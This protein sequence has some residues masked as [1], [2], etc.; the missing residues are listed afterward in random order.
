M[1]HLYPARL[2]SI[3]LVLSLLLGMVW[4]APVTE[5]E[6]V[7]GIDS[8]SC[9]GFI[10]NATA[11]NY[12]DV[13]M[14]HYLND[15]SKLRTAL[16]NGKNVIFMFEGGS[17]NYWNGS[18]YTNSA[19]DTRDQAVVNVVRKNSGGNAYIDFYSENCSS[20]PGDPSWCTGAAYSGSVTVLDGIYPV[21]TTNHTGPY[22]AL[23]LDMS[24]TNGY[25]YYTPP[26]SPDGYK[27]GCSGINVHTR[28]SD[29]A[30]GSD[31]GWAWSEGCQ[32]IG[33]G[34]TS[35]NVFN[36]FMHSVCDISWDPWIDYYASPKNLNRFASSDLYRDVGYFVID[37][38]LGLTNV[39]GTQY[40]T[41]SLRALYNTTALTNITASS[42]AARNDADFN[43]DY[44]DRCTFYRSHGSLQTLNSASV[45]SLPCAADTNGSEKLEQAA[46]GDTY[47]VTGLYSN[48]YGNYFYEIVTKGGKTGYI[49][50]ESAKYL[51]PD[52]GD[53]KITGASVPNGHVKGSVFY[54]NGTVS[55][56]C[57][58]VWKVE[59]WVRSG[60]DAA[61]TQVTGGSQTR[62]CAN[63]GKVEKQAIVAPGH[64]YAVVLKQPTCVS[65]GGFEYTCTTCG[66]HRLDTLLEQIP[67]GM[68][69]ALFETVTQYRWSDIETR[70]S[71]DTSME[72]YTQKSWIWEK[73]GSGTVEYVSSWSSGIKTSNYYYTK[74]DNK[75]SKVTASE[76]ATTKRVID[77]D[78]VSGYVYHH[79]CYSGSYYS[80]QSTSGSYTTCHVFYSTTAPSSLSNYDASD[81]SL[82]SR[83]GRTVQVVLRRIPGS[84]GSRT[85]G[86]VTRPYGVRP[87]C[88]PYL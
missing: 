20:I 2:L 77:L 34:S 47:E 52:S 85:G 40:G 73:S 62:T 48:H 6:A 13:M 50:H 19:Y 60:F 5:A 1:K 18:D 87:T 21:Y 15:N 81:G 43:V 74:Y 45:N 26:G 35:S 78:A 37:R 32:V 33:S 8:L 31:L 82:P 29:I 7:S 79:W 11:Q 54:V 65:P 56:P 9:S 36:D 63:C 61:G 53:I 46:K 30:A 64:D 84:C 88:V 17:D 10:S 44:R 72:G 4:V 25:G 38:Q 55:A 75:T 41:G 24:A 66:D 42:T 49:Y 69:P 22:A 51:G 57:T 71:Y 58:E 68:D 3:L 28:A 23:Q 67:E 16:D 27:N 76:T 14:R 83:S 80:L 39:G 70:T 86:S 12:I 59:V